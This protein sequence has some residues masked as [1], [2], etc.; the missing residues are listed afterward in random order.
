M[1]RWVLRIAL[2]SFTAHLLSLTDLTQRVVRSWRCVA[3][4]GGVG[5][6]HCCR[7]CWHRNRLSCTESGHTI[8]R[9][10]PFVI[11]FGGSPSAAVVALF[12]PNSPAFKMI[13]NGHHHHQVI[14][15]A[16]KDAGTT[17]GAAVCSPEKRRRRIRVWCDGWWVPDDWG[18]MKML[19]RRCSSFASST[20]EWMYQPDTYCPTGTGLLQVAELRQDRC[21]NSPVTHTKLLIQYSLSVILPFR[22]LMAKHI[23][24]SVQKLPASHYFSFLVSV[25]HL[26]AVD[27]LLH[28]IRAD[29]HWSLQFIMTHWHVEEASHLWPAPSSNAHTG[30][31]ILF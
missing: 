2:L 14:T 31:D 8:T 17:A 18:V 23:T 6:S 24:T 5:A 15:A 20:F 10:G 28:N 7:W 12:F 27:T 11:S 19:Q 25:F 1:L 16:G 30:C 4:R 13:K 9:H 3:G 26:S 29:L 21:F 22:V